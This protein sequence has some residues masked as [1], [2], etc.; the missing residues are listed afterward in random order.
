MN[1]SVKATE[2]EYSFLIPRNKL[3]INPPENIGNFKQISLTNKTIHDILIERKNISLKS[4]KIG[5]RL[6]K[7][8]G[9][10]EFTYKR[11]LGKDNGATKYDEIT[12]SV[13]EDIFKYF[14]TGKI[15]LFNPTLKKMAVKGTLYP[16]LQ[17]KN[18]RKIVVYSDGVNSIEVEIEKLEYSSSGNNKRVNDSMLELEIIELKSKTEVFDV[19]VDFFKKAYCGV[20]ASEGKNTRASRMLGI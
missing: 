3:N 5:V 18:K 6:R 15:D 12:E 13:S 20:T 16:L 4:E 2:R 19:L 9:Q 17:I 1:H 11:F 8:D 14:L 10:I 7:I